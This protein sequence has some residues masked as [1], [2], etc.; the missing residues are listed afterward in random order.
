MVG[1]KE[2]ETYR[3]VCELG[4]NS[5]LRKP[6]DPHALLDAIAWLRAGMETE[7]AV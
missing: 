7:S 2:H 6:A 4:A 5:F 3:H 1:R